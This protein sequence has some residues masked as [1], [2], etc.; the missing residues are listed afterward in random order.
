MKQKGLLPNHLFSFFNM[1]LISKEKEKLVAPKEK[2]AIC[3]Q[4][5]KNCCLKK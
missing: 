1:F 5:R 3:A 2:E 4:K